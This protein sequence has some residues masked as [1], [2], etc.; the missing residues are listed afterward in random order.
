MHISPIFLWNAYHLNHPI[1]NY[2]PAAANEA[3]T[4]AC[5]DLSRDSGFVRQFTPDG[6]LIEEHGTDVIF[7]KVGENE[8][9]PPF[10]RLSWI[11]ARHVCDGLHGYVEKWVLGGVHDDANIGMDFR[12][13]SRAHMES[14]WPRSKQMASM[15]M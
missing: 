13:K 4:T 2:K 14:E 15:L 6:K 9:A 12:M 8:Q 1:D 5:G 3:L 10:K 7:E 11:S